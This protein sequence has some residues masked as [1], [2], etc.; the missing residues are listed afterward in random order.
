MFTPFHHPLATHPAGTI[1]GYRTDGRPIYAIAGGSG[2]GA[3]GSGGTPPAGDPGTPPA[4]QPP[5]PAPAPSGDET[6]WKAEAR[7]WE[8]R[9]KE[10]RSA[11]DELAT[12]KQQAM[13]DQEKAV[14]AAE[15]NG[16]TAAAA[17][18]AARLAAAEFRAACAAAGVDLGEASD[19]IDT[20]RFAADGEVDTDGIK[21]AVKKLA[22]LA[23]ARGPGRS[24][25]DLGGG[26]SGDA[27]ASL[28]KQIAEAEKA[29]RWTEAIALKRRR[30][31]QT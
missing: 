25:G 26:S 19:L 24:G 4:A 21:A 29:G 11:A 18:Y 1:L 20:S 8:Q 7:K 9:A 27:P 10:N 6:D 23:S 3:A 13:T 30:A 2:E 15:K 28:D 14:A 5:A 12:L 22:K 17:E 16:R 31:A